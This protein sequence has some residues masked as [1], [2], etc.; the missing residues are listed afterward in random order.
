M[1]KYIR[2]Q[3]GLT[4]KDVALYL[5]VSMH[6]VQSM[7]LG[8]RSVPRS[9]EDAIRVLLDVIVKG[10]P[11]TAKAI[12]PLAMPGYQMKQLKSLHRKLS[13][14][15]R[16]YVEQLEKTKLSYAEA[17]PRLDMYQQIADSLAPEHADTPARLKW[18][19]W[20]MAVENKRISDNN[21]TT[22]AMLAL[23]IAALESKIA[24]IA[25]LIAGG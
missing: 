13:I 24:G 25:A 9:C 17:H 19:K 1:T 8:R 10:K 4:W 11:E 23:E 18:V 16:K 7:E 2:E 22:Q 15:R 3:L 5:N 21:P 12:V 20:R 14:R 6:M